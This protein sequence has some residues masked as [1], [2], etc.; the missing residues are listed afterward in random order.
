MNE[1]VRE[2]FREIKDGQKDLFDLMRE[3][4]QRF[5][6]HRIESVAARTQHS[7]RLDALEEASAGRSGMR[8][9]VILAL[10][11]TVF[12]AVAGFGADLVRFIFKAKGAGVILV[13]ALLAGCG[14]PQSVVRTNALNGEAARWIAEKSEDAGIDR[15]AVTIAAGSDVIARKIGVPEEPVVY[16]PEVH[17]ATVVQAGK[18]VDAQD[19]VKRGISD[20][21]TGLVTKGADL[22]FPGLGGLL[23]GLLAF[24]RK[25]AQFDKLKKGASV[26]VD[27]VNKLPPEVSRTV[28]G[29][30]ENAAAKVGAGDLVK[31]VVK[32]LEK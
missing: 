17:E 24:V 16:S 8:Q 1:E 7:Q 11:A 23:V 5:S 30:V 2:A 15:A 26:I 12:G 22:I 29:A 10:I 13:G 3:Q 18:D 32:A 4:T 20:W 27:T 28:K 9:N 21:V 6:E 19:A 25:S 14:T 31:G